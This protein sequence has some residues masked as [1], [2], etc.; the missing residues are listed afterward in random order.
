MPKKQRGVI[1][2]FGEEAARHSFR[3]LDGDR[4]VDHAV[5]AVYLLSS[6][7]THVYYRTECSE[8]ATLSVIQRACHLCRRGIAEPGLGF[9]NLSL[10]DLFST[11]RSKRQDC[12]TLSLLQHAILCNSSRLIKSNVPLYGRTWIRIPCRLLT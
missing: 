3:A 6:T 10:R 4:L 12:P 2:A 1:V 7:L 5:D 11:F 8:M 9:T